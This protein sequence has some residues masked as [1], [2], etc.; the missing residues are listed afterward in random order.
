MHRIR[1][2]SNHT[3][4]RVRSRPEDHTALTALGGG[5]YGPAERPMGGYVTLP[6][7]L[8]TVAVEEWIEKSLVYVAALPAK[9]PKPTKE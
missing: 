3:C 7:S 1:C 8:S 9:K 2:I 5:P 6:N 4:R